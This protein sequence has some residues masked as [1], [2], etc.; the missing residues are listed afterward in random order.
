MYDCQIEVKTSLQILCSV[1]RSESHTTDAEIIP[2]TPQ[3]D[4]G[5]FSEAGATTAPEDTIDHVVVE[6]AKKQMWMDFEVF[7]KCFK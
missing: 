1:G 6:E 7:C 4:D 5:G 3:G 2:I